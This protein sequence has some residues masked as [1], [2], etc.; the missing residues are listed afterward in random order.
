MGSTL[1]YLE[2]HL[3]S[4]LQGF[5]RTRAG[6]QGQGLAPGRAWNLERWLLGPVTTGEPRE[7]GREWAAEPGSRA[8]G[9]GGRGPVF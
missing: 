5:L 1:S 7:A 4:C 6:Q 2:S 9:G 3:H 8:L